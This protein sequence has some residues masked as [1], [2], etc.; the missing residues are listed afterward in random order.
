MLVVVDVVVVVVVEVV[1]VVLVGV[2]DDV[3]VVVL[4]DVVV[5]LQT[6][7]ERVVHGDRSRTVCV[8]LR[9]V[10]SLLSSVHW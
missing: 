3:V 7:G 5:V 8:R 2:L 10:A 1:V 6:T 4:V 9:S